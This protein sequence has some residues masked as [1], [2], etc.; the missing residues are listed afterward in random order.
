M[1]VSPPQQIQL[2]QFN[3]LPIA[4]AHSQ[5]SEE[6]IQRKREANQQQK[7]VVQHLV[8][9]LPYVEKY[10]LS[11]S[12]HTNIYNF[13]DDLY[14][15]FIDLELSSKNIDTNSIKSQT[16]LDK[17]S[18]KSLLYADPDGDKVIVL[19]PP[20]GSDINIDIRDYKDIG[21]LPFIIFSIT[22]DNIDRVRIEFEN[23]SVDKDTNPLLSGINIA[24]HNTR[25]QHHVEQQK[26]V[27]I[28]Q[29]IPIIQQQYE[30]QPIIVEPQQMTQQ[31]PMI[32]LGPPIQQQ[33][34]IMQQPIPIVQEPIQYVN[35]GN[36]MLG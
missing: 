20:S 31:L 18:I 16:K 14:G 6:D 1:L 27:Q 36:V 9:K 7:A 13:G 30:V 5:K 23:N 19:D 35:N 2:Q 26:Q 25:T 34:P 10:I 17:S 28:P 33:F 22:P 4:S 32:P 11:V 3:N 8:S 21:K 24:K 15:A 29:Q 12:A